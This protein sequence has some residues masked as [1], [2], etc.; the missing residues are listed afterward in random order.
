M[1]TATIARLATTNRQIQI[2]TIVVEQHS[3]ARSIVLHLAPGILIL[4]LFLVTV[5]FVMSAGYPALLAFLIS[6]IGGGLAFQVAHLYYEGRRRNA[7]WSLEGIVLYREPMRIR[8]YLILVPLV[9]VVAFMVNGLTQPLGSYLLGLL[10]W[11]PEWFELRDV[12]LLAAFPRPVLALTMGL[13]LLLNGVAAPIVEE[14][15]FRGYLMPRLA[16]FGRWTPVV[17]MGL[18]S[19]YH[20]WQPYY[21]VTVF[22]GTLPYGYLV[23]WKRNIKLG[24]VTHMALNLIGGLLYTALLLG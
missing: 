8:Q 17:E 18:F 12:S 15:Y 16:R 2:E 14:M 9:A 13:Y 24:I 21:W 1:A 23:W 6:G 7:K 19:L 20:F 5:P 3:L 22:L 11:L 4:S 10:S